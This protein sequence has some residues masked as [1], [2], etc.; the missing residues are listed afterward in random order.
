MLRFKSRKQAVLTIVI[1]ILIS[2]FL[3]LFALHNFLQNY[4]FE[5]IFPREDYISCDDD[6]FSYIQL[7]SPKKNLCTLFIIKK[8]EVDAKQNLYTNDVIE[9]NIIFNDRIVKN[10]YWGVNSYDLFFDSKEKGIYCY[11]Y[12]NDSWTGEFYFDL[13]RTKEEHEKGNKDV[14][15]FI[16]D[17][18]NKNA[19]KQSGLYE[20]ISAPILRDTIPKVI[21]D[22]IDKKLD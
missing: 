14:Y 11:I 21:L 13:T 18:K 15:Y 19:E 12:D 7:S 2:M 22:V 1:L 6:N 9:S 5:N 3:V 17:I 16:G 20:K 4:Y 10:I 8:I